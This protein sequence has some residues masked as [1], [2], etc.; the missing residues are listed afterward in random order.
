MT[1][2]ERQR[3]IRRIRKRE[4]KAE[5]Q[6]DPSERWKTK[7]PGK[8]R[9]NLAEENAWKIKRNVECLL[10]P[11]TQAAP[12]AGTGSRAS[13]TAAA[14]AQAVGRQHQRQRKGADENG[15]LPPAGP[16]VPPL[17]VAGR[18]QRP[19][20]G[21]RSTVRTAR[22]HGSV[23]QSRLYCLANSQVYFLSIPPTHRVCNYFKCCRKYSIINYQTYN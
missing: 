21:P 14:A 16:P 15:P 9:C 13:P 8:I 3:D 5:I 23:R 20:H 18:L 12:A 11:A 2:Q 22:H 6:K 4:F 1:K 19:D 10:L 17:P 7:I